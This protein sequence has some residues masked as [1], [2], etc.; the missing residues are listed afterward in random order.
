MSPPDLRWTPHSLAKLPD[1]FP[2]CRCSQAS[3]MRKIKEIL[4]LKFEAKI[5]SRADCRRDRCFQRR[6]QQLRSPRAAEGP[7]LAAAG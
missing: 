2:E 7:E 3:A 5:Q 1:F 4:R 6:C